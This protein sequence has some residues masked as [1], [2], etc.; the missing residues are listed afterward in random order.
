MRGIWTAVCVMALVL[1]ASILDTAKVSAAE[2][3]EFITDVAIGGEGGWDI[4]TIDPDARRLYLSHSTK[5][6][7]VDIDA[8]K[9]AGEIAD[10]PGVHAFLPVATA[11]RGF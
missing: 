3:Y 7:V 8:N 2:P 5:I 1:S 6:V 9:I 4:L 11:Q 10:T